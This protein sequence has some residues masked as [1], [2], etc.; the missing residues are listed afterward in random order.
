[1]NRVKVLI[2]AVLL[3]IFLGQ[4]FAWAGVN[5]KSVFLIV[6]GIDSG[7]SAK[8]LDNVIFSLTKAK[9]PFCL[10]VNVG[11]GFAANPY[12]AKNINASLSLGG[13]VL[14]DAGTLADGNQ[15]AVAIDKLIDNNII[16]FGVICGKAAR[17]VVNNSSL[18]QYCSTLITEGDIPF[19]SSDDKFQTVL[20]SSFK[21]G[22][23]S[24]FYENTVFYQQINKMSLLKDPFFGIS[25]DLD[26]DSAALLKLAHNLKKQG[27]VFQDLKSLPSYV[28]SRNA[29]IFFKPEYYANI[30]AREIVYADILKLSLLKFEA[31]NNYVEES[32]FDQAFKLISRKTS[33]ALVNGTVLIDLIGKNGIFVVRQL[34][35]GS[36]QLKEVKQSL[37]AFIF[38]KTSAGIIEDAYRLVAA[39][40]F[41]MTFFMML[42]LIF[43]LFSSRSKSRGL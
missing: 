13:A 28:R 43:I 12:L 33:G 6:Q 7:T 41:L 39:S 38:G 15:V 18:N 1:M 42:Y 11:N 23:K 36:G 32:L 4:S 30:P 21:L 20:S 29:A 27:Y 31:K 17:D 2:L 3:T 16:P 34:P 25:V 40:V 8:K 14:L 10:A 22:K 24:D 35:L 19:K 5:K 9:I 37:W 26:F